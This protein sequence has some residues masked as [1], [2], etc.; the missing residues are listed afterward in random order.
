MSA[1][2][3][4]FSIA[5]CLRAWEKIGAAPLTR[6]CL[7]DKKVRRELG[8]AEDDQNAVMA[9]LEEA[10]HA[11]VDFLNRRGYQGD[12]MKATVQRVPKQKPVTAPHTVAMQLLL[13]KA[14][15]HGAKFHATGGS[16]VTSH[17]MFKAL[18]IPI[19]CRRRSRPIRTTRTPGWRPNVSR[20]RPAV[21]W[22]RPRARDLLR[23]RA[24]HPNEVAPDPHAPGIQQ[25]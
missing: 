3:V 6:K 18:E 10:N 8:D 5:A 2:E 9:A 19:L 15:I 24:H 20:R 12:K 4:A 13:S 1:F 11:A 17:D 7:E 14:S 21:S 22:P 16:H 25:T 23:P